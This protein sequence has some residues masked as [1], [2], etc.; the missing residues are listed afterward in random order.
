M[1]ALSRR[2]GAVRGR[3]VLSRL[4]CRVFHRW[5]WARGRCHRWDVGFLDGVMWVVQWGM[6]LWR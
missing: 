1:I 2:P 3:Q 6:L 5:A 4:G